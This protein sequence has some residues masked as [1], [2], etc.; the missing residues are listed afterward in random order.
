MGFP[1][2][3]NLQSMPGNRAAQH[4]SVLA[5]CLLTLLLFWSTAEAAGNLSFSD[6][7]YSH[8]VFAPL[9]CI[10]LLYWKRQDIFVNA[11]YSPYFGI[12]LLASSMLLGFIVMDRWSPRN[13]TTGLLLVVFAIVLSWIAGFILCYGLQSFR[14][15][16]YPLSCLFLMLPIPSTW[17][18]WI[19]AGSVHGSANASHAILQAVGVSVFRDGMN[20]SVPGLNFQIAP[21]CSGIHSGLAFLIVG[22]VSGPLFLRT[23][24]VRLVLILST[25]PIAI[26]K[27]AVRIVVIAL[28]GAYVDLDIIDGPLHRYSGFVFTPLTFICFVPL[29][30]AL[31][32]VELRMCCK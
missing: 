23:G 8:I 17:M 3:P 31:R 1:P 25:I 2:L 6:E 5:I 10:F 18:D 24:W 12:P 7:R 30:L 27:N 21:Q 11:R 20:F 29:V 4:L 15:A 26:F 32:K 19:T 13:E 9:F 14:R 28:L 16:I 22:I